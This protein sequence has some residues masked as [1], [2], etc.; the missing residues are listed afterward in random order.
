[1]VHSSHTVPGDELTHHCTCPP[2]MPIRDWANTSKD[3]QGQQVPKCSPGLVRYPSHS[4]SLKAT[5]HISHL[6]SVTFQTQ[7]TLPHEIRTVI[8][9]WGTLVYFFGSGSC[10]QKH[11]GN[12]PTRRATPPPG[13]TALVTLASLI[14]FLKMKIFQASFESKISQPVGLR[15]Q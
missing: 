15:F 1:M 14:S 5:H 11:E 2:F 7:T 13:D 3:S 10:E 8:L 4:R 9:T 6:D 12:Q